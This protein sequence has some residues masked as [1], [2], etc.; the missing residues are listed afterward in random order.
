MTTQLSEDFQQVRSLIYNQTA[1]DRRHN[2]PDQISAEHTENAMLLLTPNAC[3]SLT[4]AM[5]E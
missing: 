2:V 1:C 5:E 4:S 3:R